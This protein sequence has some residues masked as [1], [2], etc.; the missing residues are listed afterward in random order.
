MECALG[1][2]PYSADAN[3]QTGQPVSFFELLDFI[4]QSPAPK[5]P[6]G[7]FSAE[8]CDFVESCLQKAPEERPSAPELLAHPFIKKYQ[9]DNIG[10][11]ATPP[12]LLCF[13]NIFRHGRMGG[14]IG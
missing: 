11:R 9:N 2:Y 14:I 6:A 4:V 13:H 10:I 12:Y 8:F 1:R 3:A 7:T 5:L